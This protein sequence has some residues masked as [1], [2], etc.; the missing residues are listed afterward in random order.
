MLKIRIETNNAAFEGNLKNEI[1]YCLEMIR[2]AI[3][4][5]EKDWTI[6]DSNGNNVGNLTLTNR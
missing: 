5:G 1:C 2:E 4:R 6:H 3:L